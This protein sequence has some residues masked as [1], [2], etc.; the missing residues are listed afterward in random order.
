MSTTKSVLSH[1]VS[2][3]SNTPET[4]RPRIRELRLRR[5]RAFENARLILND[6]TVVVG[7]NGSGKST[8][9]EVFDFVQDAVM[10]SVLTALERRGGINSIVHRPSS[11]RHTNSDVEIAI[12]IALPVTNVLYGFTLAPFRSRS[13]YLVKRETLKTYPKESFSRPTLGR[14][15]RICDVK[16]RPSRENEKD[17]FGYVFRVSRFTRYPE[18]LRNGASVKPY[19]TFVTGSAISMA[20]STSALL[21]RWLLGRCTILLIPP[22]RS[23]AVSTECITASCTKSNASISVDLPEPLRPTIIVKSLRISR[24]FSKARKRRRRSSRMRGR[25]VS[26]VLLILD[27]L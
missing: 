12:D 7:R 10:H 27:T 2:A 24:A 22:R 19:R 20:I 23:S 14:A 6:L 17:S 21:C 9:M 3:M 11:Q 8:L 16:S 13:G 26:T 25:M 1:S 15:P 18:R 4:M 5:F